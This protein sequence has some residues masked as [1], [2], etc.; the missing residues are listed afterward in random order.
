ME[1]GLSSLSL[2]VPGGKKSAYFCFGCWPLSFSAKTSG[3]S[4]WGRHPSIPSPTHYSV[5][6]CLPG[7]YAYLPIMLQGCSSQRC[8][9]EKLDD[10][11]VG[12]NCSQM[13]CI[14]SCFQES[15]IVELFSPGSRFWFFF[16]LDIFFERTP[17]TVWTPTK[18][19]LCNMSVE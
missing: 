12:P 15:T 5:Y 13:A 7:S 8:L 14:T 17:E 10:N 3:D 9:A 19:A 16:W 6:R 11:T 2:T 4:L 18:L 1:K